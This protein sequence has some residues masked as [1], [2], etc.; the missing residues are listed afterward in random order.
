MQNLWASLNV[1]PLHFLTLYRLHSL[2]QFLSPCSLSQETFSILG[3]L[4]LDDVQVWGRFLTCMLDRGRMIPR[5][6]GFTQL[7]TERNFALTKANLLWSS[8]NQTWLKSAFIRRGNAQDVRCRHSAKDGA[9][10]G[11]PALPQARSLVLVW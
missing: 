11:N 9:Y 2:T 5:H 7:L 8:S 3:Q 4:G 6:L 1:R 10:V